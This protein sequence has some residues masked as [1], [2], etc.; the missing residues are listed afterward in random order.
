[1]NQN[2]NKISTIILI[3][4]IIVPILIIYGQVY[5]FGWFSLDDGAYIVYNKYVIQG[6]V[7]DSIKWAWQYFD[8][9]YYMPLT[10]LSFLMDSSIYGINPKGFHITN[11]LLHSLNS[12]LVFYFLY[13]MTNEKWKSFFVAILFAIHPQHVEAVVWISE[14]KEVLAAFFGL[15][16]LSFYIKH[17]QRNIIL[18]SKQY[19][20][21]S[22]YYLLSILFFIFSL[23]SKPVWITFP[24]LLL[25]LDFWPLERYKYLSIVD[26]IIEKI[27]FF[28]ISFVF[29]AV[30]SVTTT[31]L[32]LDIRYSVLE[33]PIHS[34]ALFPFEERLGNS[35]V[36]Y[37]IYFWKSFFPFI[38]TGYQPYPS[39]LLPLWKI[40]SAG[41]SLLA[42]TLAS[43]F[44][45]KQKPYFFFGWLWFLG[46]L[47]PL[48]GI[49]NSGGESIFIGDR[50]TYLP[51]I[52]FFMAIIWG[53]APF[54]SYQ[55]R[56]YRSVFFMVLLL[57]FVL[58]IYYAY[59]HTSYWRDN[60][61]YWTH[62]IEK[63]KNN[64]F[65]HNSLGEAYHINQRND[66]A[67][68]HYSEAQRLKPEEVHYLVVAGNALI[69]LQR[70]KQAWLYHSKILELERTPRIILL[71]MGIGFVNYQQDYRAEQFFK[72]LVETN[73]QISI[74]NKEALAKYHA[75]FS[76]LFFE[77]HV[78]L[79]YIYLRS[80]RL[81]EANREFEKYLFEFP[82]NDIS[83]CNYAYGIFKAN[84]IPIYKTFC[85]E[86]E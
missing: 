36:A 30:Y 11:L 40:Y 53:A 47:F 5:Y 13:V 63:N 55:R 74:K 64:H 66:E 31:Y 49:V 23:L 17:V 58:N 84:M 57:I 38:F 9:P 70:W 76:K 19:F 10:R 60:I 7:L 72:K 48:V 59:Q 81:E 73:K 43:I 52:G 44:Y 68:E 51:H 25:L 2:N 86:L 4:G 20:T 41:L 77:P 78:Y 24:C 15:L 18:S 1:M 26:L 27:P 29:F 50:W 65:A 34:I 22:Y 56:F 16:G 12:I 39:S 75:S 8:N 32:S 71:S 67:F 28:F 85:N 45:I 35:L 62:V 33:T 46:T 61:T 80:G 21:G 42:I 14:R 37:I 6:F 54:I 3:A 69:R 83:A 82:K 79:S